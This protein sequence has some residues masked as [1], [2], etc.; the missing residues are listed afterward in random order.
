MTDMYSRT[1]VHPLP[2][3]PPLVRRF[4]F[5]AEWFGP[6]Y[7]TFLRDETLRPQANEAVLAAD[8]RIVCDMSVS[9]TV[10]RAAQDLQ[11]FLDVCMGIRLP[12]VK[13]ATAAATKAISL[14]LPLPLG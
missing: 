14:S 4:P 11:A 8:W 2:S 13:Q 10:A 7:T 1:I 5:A 9:P 6:V 3:E 12:V